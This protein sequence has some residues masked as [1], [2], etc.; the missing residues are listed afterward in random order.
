MRALRMM[1]KRLRAV[2]SSSSMDASVLVVTMLSPA[3]CASLSI[4]AL[5]SIASACF[6]AC[7]FLVHIT[8]PCCMYMQVSFVGACILACM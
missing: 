3:C 8:K 2:S 6:L 4:R 1:L 5:I 7:T